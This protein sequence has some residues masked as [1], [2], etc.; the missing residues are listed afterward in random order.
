MSSFV[1]FFTYLPLIFFLSFFYNFYYSVYVMMESWDVRDAYEVAGLVYGGF[2][3]MGI[4]GVDFLRDWFRDLKC[5]WHASLTP[6]NVLCFVMMFLYKG[7]DFGFSSLPCVALFA[8]DF[9][10]SIDGRCKADNDGIPNVEK[11]NNKEWE[12]GKA[13]E[14]KKAEYAFGLVKESRTLW[15]LI[16]LWSLYFFNDT[17]D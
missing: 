16:S 7:N 2:G 9:F 15:T 4:M 3:Q 12:R 8:F 1:F 11:E 14:R 17:A 6:I 5:F 10:S 13:I